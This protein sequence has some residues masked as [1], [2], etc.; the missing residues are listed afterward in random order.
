MMP[1]GVWVL[2]SLLLTAKVSQ[3]AKP[4]EQ[5][6]N[7]ITSNNGNGG[8]NANDN[9]P[10]AS[11]MVSLSGTVV[12]SPALRDLSGDGKLEVLISCMDGYVYI[13]DHTGM[14]LPGW[15]QL[16]GNRP[17]TNNATDLML[18][19]SPSVGD[20]DGDGALDIVV[21]APSGL[22]FA[23]D[24]DGTA[25]DNFPVDLE[26][27]IQSTCA[28]IDLNDDEIA[29]IIVHSSGRRL[30]VLDGN[31]NALSGWPQDLGNASVSSRLLSIDSS[32]TVFDLHLDGSLQIAVGSTANKVHLFNVDGSAVSGWPLATDDWVCSS[33][34]MVDLTGDYEPEIVAGSA[35][36]KLYAWNATCDLL[37]GFPVDLGA[38]IVGAVAAADLTGNGFNELVAATMDGSV[39][40]VNNEGGVLS[41]W[42]KTV[43]KAI[44]AAPILIDADADNLL[45][46]VVVAL[47]KRIH[48]WSAD[49]SVIPSLSFKMNNTIESAPAAGDVDGDGLIEFV[50]VS[51]DGAMQ[52]LE[53]E[54]AAT[55]ANLVWPGFRGDRSFSADSVSTD[56]DGD[57]LPDALEFALFGSYEM[58]GDGDYDGDGVSNLSE[59]IVG[60]SLLDRSDRF[61]VAAGTI[62]VGGVAQVKLTWKGLAG[63]LYKVYSCASL[64]G[65]EDWELVASNAS[66]YVTEPANMA[67]THP[68][69]SDLPSQFY[70]VVV[71]R[72]SYE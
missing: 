70:K 71:E 15:P 56:V 37:P 7:E 72:R 22:L 29:E 28:L 39:Y 64:C 59:W 55:A 4:S 63:R 20:I 53:L 67:W 18:V 52:V 24:L 10:P 11:W 23:W 17:M 68:V 5:S 45:D 27:P 32:P 26:D 30:H 65:N 14:V 42:P 35:D 33:V 19:A 34:T 3:G 44:A 40:V 2:V 58:A 61:S 69:Q 60:T 41:A 57:R 49:G 13:F 43:N 8:N 9:R 36:N 46:V 31:G 66:Q 6:S 12:A 47:D 51:T 16:V 21:G 62:Q 25:K 54:S 38:D 50:Y 1:I 48:A